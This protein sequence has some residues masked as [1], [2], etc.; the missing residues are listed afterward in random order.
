M[1][2]YEEPVI[3]NPAEDRNKFD[4]SPRLCTIPTI[5]PAAHWYSGLTANHL[6][7]LWC[8]YLGW[9][10]DGY[11]QYA[12]IIGLPS[13]L[14]VLLSPAQ[15]HRSSVY[16][17]L[18]LCF[19]LIGWG[20]GGL[21]GGMLADYLGRK[22]MMMISVFAYALFSALS[23]FSQSFTMLALFRFMTGLAIGSEWSTGVTLIA[24]T[25]PDNA[26]A[27]GC[28]F[29]QSAIGAGM[30]IAVSAWY[31][32]THFNPSGQNW[33]ILFLI[34]G[35]PA[36]LVLYLRRGLEE[37]ERWATAVK[38][39]Q[40]NTRE[41]SSVHVASLDE[42]RPF[43]LWAIWRDRES[44]ARLLLTSLLS[45]TTVIGW[46]TV[47]TLLPQFANQLASQR[48]AGP[49][50]GSRA[51]MV[52]LIGAI[53][54]YCFSGFLI[55][56]LGRRKFIALSYLGALVLTP[57]TYLWTGSLIMFLAVAFVSGFLTQGCCY[58]W[59]AIYVAELFSSTVRATAC[60]FV[61]NFPR[62]VAA[63]FPVGAGLMIESLGGTSRAAVTIG[64]IYIIGVIVPW[65]LPETLGQKV[66]Q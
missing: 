26:R 61:F 34:G 13:A 29:L 62:F 30:L 64:C 1:G 37:S 3:V 36:F 57:I 56:L 31:L 27:K 41:D 4:R 40:W 6:R 47:S 11:E 15:L 66:P 20:V 22:R 25:W 54:A 12:V 14:Q 10:F 17:G 42:E 50:W 48:H 8:C 45:M 53:V 49:S 5:Q 43:P 65:F 23:A 32:L 55:D 9:M 39:R 18:I 44:R 52:Y 2:K 35:L 19:T 46:W 63:L 51:A 38:E 33:R 16:F 7:T 24:E 60:S 28:G 59:S 58:A 21:A